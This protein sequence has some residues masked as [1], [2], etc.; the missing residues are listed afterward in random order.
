MPKFYQFPEGFL[1]G[2]ATSSYQIEGA[3]N[4]DGKGPSIWDVFSHTQGKIADGSTGDVACD[5]YHRWREDVALMKELG[6]KAYRFSVSW[7]RVLPQGRGP[8]NSKGLDFYDRL[9]DELL[10]NGIEPF[11]TLYHWDLP[12]ALQ[13]FGG[14]VNRDI[15][16]W[17]ADYAA[18]VARR[19]GD[20]VRW[21]ATHNE[22]WV[23]AWIGHGWG[24]HAPGL[25]NPR[26]ALQV[27]HHLL[28]S[29]GL[30]V[31]VLRDATGGAARIGIVL[32]LT[33]VHPASDTAED[34][35]AA[36]RA[37]GFSNRWFLDPLFW[38]SYPKD[39]WEGFGPMV[40]EV[41]P[42]DMACIS[43]RLDFLGVNYYTRAVVAH[44][45]QGGP[46]QVKSVRPE[47]SAYTE[48]GW[49]I[50]PQGLYELLIRL[51]RDYKP[52]TIIITENGAAFA[53][54]V[55]ADGRVHD[56]PRIDYL[57]DHLVQAHRAIREGVPL[58]GYF[59]WS[60]MD[61]FEWAHGYT[62]RFG[63]VYVDF[64]T[65]RRIPKDSALWYRDVIAANGLT[66]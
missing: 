56:Q 60:L 64:S 47:K 50:Y 63:L 40:P 2:V 1:W 54:V 33:S 39:L 25:R 23:V 45:A 4:E 7:P 19:L 38:G 49:E 36:H 8:V 6:I 53:D 12:Q 5:H 30:A 18:V 26:C 10:K 31:E 14:W 65:Q 35:A 66:V 61:N 51:H 32:N 55:S 29:H 21:W 16:K 22:P 46:L 15:A 9:V 48:M 13:D 62:K 43:R 28:L 24:E 3:W 52:A 42:G 17:F 20:R 57:R 44:D 59:V 58:E 11:L 37:D 27:A 41:H 34:H